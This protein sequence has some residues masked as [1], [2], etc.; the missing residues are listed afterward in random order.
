MFG[1]FGQCDLLC[2]R[3]EYSGNITSYVHPTEYTDKLVML[4]EV[5]RQQKKCLFNKL[6]DKSSV[7]CRLHTRRT[8]AKRLTHE[9][10]APQ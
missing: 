2:S 4:H 10:R 3:T 7:T 6:K 9:G 5:E 1:L 8:E